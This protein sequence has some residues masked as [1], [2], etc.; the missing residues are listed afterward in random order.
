MSRTPEQQVAD[1]A[2][3]LAHA[4]EYLAEATAALAA[5]KGPKNPFRGG[6]ML[7]FEVE[8]TR[9]GPAYS[10]GALFVGDKFFTTGSRCPTSGY[11]W[12]QF[13]E[14]LGKAHTVRN[15]SVYRDGSGQEYT[16]ESP[17]PG[18]PTALLPVPTPF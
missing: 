6:D 17:A 3:A 16:F 2:R 7:R 10:Y 4:T 11:T 13:L 15:V 18:L 8:H 12:K 1:A 5:S 14:F 9:G